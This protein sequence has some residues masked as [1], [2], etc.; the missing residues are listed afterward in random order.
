MLKKVCYNSNVLKATKGELPMKLGE[1]IE[2]MKLIFKTIMAI[3]SKDDPN[4]EG[5]A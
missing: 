3:F 2:L 1:F 5:N 4:S